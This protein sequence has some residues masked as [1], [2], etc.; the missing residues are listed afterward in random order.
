M[1]AYQVELSGMAIV[2]QT[3]VIL[4]DSQEEAERIALDSYNDNEWQYDELD[5]VRNNVD[6][7]SIHQLPSD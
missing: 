4:A 5:D 2:R 6:I 7:E 3:Q 1:P